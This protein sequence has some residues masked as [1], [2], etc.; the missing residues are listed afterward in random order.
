MSHNSTLQN[1]TASTRAQ[2]LDRPTIFTRRCCTN[3]QF[4]GR[5]QCQASLS[6]CHSGGR[7]PLSLT[8]ASVLK[9]PLNPNQP[10]NPS[11]YYMTPADWCLNK[12]QAYVTFAH[13]KRTGGRRGRACSAI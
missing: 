6:I 9:V 1:V 12:Q 11:Q 8:K 7:H 5:P 10:T 4:I 2:L 3:L 13:L